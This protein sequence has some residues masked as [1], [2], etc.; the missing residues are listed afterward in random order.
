MF[1]SSRLIALCTPNCKSLWIKASA[2]RLNVKVNVNLIKALWRQLQPQV[3]FGYDASSFAHL[4]YFLS[5]SSQA[6]SG[7]LE[8]IGGQSCIGFSKD[9]WLQ[10]PAPSGPLEDVHR[11]VS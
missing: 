1:A 6:L 10:V 9:I 7:W 11:V 5:P 3:F 4:H 2:K 8:T